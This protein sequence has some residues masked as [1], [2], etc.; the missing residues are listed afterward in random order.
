MKYDDTR[1]IKGRALTRPKQKI[2]FT[3]AEPLPAASPGS[4]VRKNKKQESKDT[5]EK[6][7]LYTFILFSGEKN[8]PK[9]APTFECPWIENPHQPSGSNF[10]SAD[11]L[12]IPLYLQEVQKN[13]PIYV[14]LF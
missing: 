7:D 1:W 2:T 5:K 6:D 14:L 9:N 8:K 12:C 3:F 10:I 4:L 13:N 11:P